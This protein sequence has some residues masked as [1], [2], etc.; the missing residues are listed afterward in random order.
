MSEKNNNNN[1]EL[2]NP[3]RINYYQF[4]K[5]LIKLLEKHHLKLKNVN[6]IDFVNDEENDDSIKGINTNEKLELLDN[7]ITSINNIIP[8]KVRIV[9]VDE[10]TN[11]KS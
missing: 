3:I 1:N 4:L 7:I 10:K 9:I 8:A 5:D 11:S 2:G 6:D